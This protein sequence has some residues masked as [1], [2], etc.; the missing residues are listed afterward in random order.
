MYREYRGQSYERISAS[1]PVGSPALVPAC[2]SAYATFARIIMFLLTGMG[3]F[4]M[5][6]PSRPFDVC[7]NTRPPYSPAVRSN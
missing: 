7:T 4:L 6:R 5:Q 1:N 2:S 3:H